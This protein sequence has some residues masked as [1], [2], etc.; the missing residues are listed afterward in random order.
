MSNM[1]VDYAKRIEEEIKEDSETLKIKNV[2]KFD[3]KRH[4]ESNIEDLMNG[5]IMQI[6]GTMVNTKIF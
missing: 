1:S 5:N 6:L 2:G 4:L 3:P